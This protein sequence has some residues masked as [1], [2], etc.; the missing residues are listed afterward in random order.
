MYG[1]LLSSGD[2]D[3]IAAQVKTMDGYGRA[4]EAYFLELLRGTTGTA[5]ALRAQFVGALDRPIAELSP[6]EHAILLIATY[7]LVHRPEVPYRVVIN[8]AVELAKG[9]GGAEGFRYVNGV[10]DKLAG[11]IRVHE[12]GAGRVGR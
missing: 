7:E 12:A 1:W 6:I 2:A 4:D 5:E 11:R 9:F 10:L 8:E 3:A